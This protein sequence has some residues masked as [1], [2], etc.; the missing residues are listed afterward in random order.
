MP[1][2]DY[3]NEQCKICKTKIKKVYIYPYCDK[4]KSIIRPTEFIDYPELLLKADKLR[5]AY[6]KDIITNEC[7]IIKRDRLLLLK[8]R[9]KDKY[10]TKL[11]KEVEQI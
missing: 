8:E 4:C 5:E 11:K 7:F 9:A 6:N 10:L 3:K 1:K 2:W